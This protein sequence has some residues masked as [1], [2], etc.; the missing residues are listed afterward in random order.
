MKKIVKILNNLQKL[1][2]PR[3]TENCIGRNVIIKK[4]MNIL[5]WILFGIMIIALADE[6]KIREN[7]ISHLFEAQHILIFGTISYYKHIFP[8][9]RSVFG[10]K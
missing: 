4:K 10:I 7:I 6:N 9:C 5:V 2:P 8:H 3:K 1:N